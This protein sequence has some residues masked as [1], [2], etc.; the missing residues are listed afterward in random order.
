MKDVL[1][2]SYKQTT[3]FSFIRLACSMQF[4]FVADKSIYCIYR[5]KAVPFKCQA[6]LNRWHDPTHA[7]VGDQVRYQR[8]SSLDSRGI[9][10]RKPVAPT[11]TPVCSSVWNVYMA[12]R[13]QSLDQK[14]M[15]ISW[16]L[17]WRCSVFSFRSRFMSHSL[18][19]PLS[20]ISFIILSSF[21]TSLCF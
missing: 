15:C 9:C 8:T 18:S 17:L 2:C 7:C 13:P 4:Y 5:R 20:S 14:W 1:S 12:L 11:H 6:P 10:A 16:K 21:L 3:L 19:I